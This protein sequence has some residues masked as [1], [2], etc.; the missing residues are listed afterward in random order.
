[1]VAVTDANGVVATAR[2]EIGAGVSITPSVAIVSPNT[3][4]V[5]AASGGSGADFQ[6]AMITNAS[7]GVIDP[8]S[9]TYTAGPTADVIDIVRV[10]DSL[11]N[12]ADVSI[13]VGAA[14][15][16]TPTAPQ[17]APREATTFT[18]TGGSGEYQFSLL[19]NASGASIDQVSGAYVAGATPNVVDRVKVVDRLGN[20]AQV[21]VSVGAGLSIR[22]QT[23]ALPAGGTTTF[24]VS[25]GSGAGYAWSLA[26]NASGG[27]IDPNAGAYV[28]GDRG[29]EDGV[30]VTDSFGN[31]ATATVTVTALPALTPGADAGSDAGATAALPSVGDSGCTCHTSSGV[32]APDAGGALLAGLVGLLL[33]RKR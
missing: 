29:G 16:L 2:V 6:W 22:P 12:S 23:L 26:P 9:G 3:S 15:L 32:T 31:L 11:L 27:S 10:T 33:R 5:L 17:V 14:L 21:D 7:A 30:Q 19:T 20:Q 8:V 28:A 25:G 1:M 24:A 4:L 18:A 13:V